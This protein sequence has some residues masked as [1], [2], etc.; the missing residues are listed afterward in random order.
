MAWGMYLLY[1]IPNPSNGRQHFGGSALALD[2][3]SFFGWAP[4]DGSRVQIY[5]GF[6]AL[7]LNLVVAAVVTVVLRATGT[8]EGQDLTRPEDYHATRVSES[9]TPDAVA[10]V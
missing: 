6:L 3:L 7:I 10:Q 5:V 4:W 8:R 1:L 2:K 9:T